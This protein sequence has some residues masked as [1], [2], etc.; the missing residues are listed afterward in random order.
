MAA[1]RSETQMTTSQL[2]KRMDR[3]EVDV[4]ELKTEV[5][6]TTSS[7]DGMRGDMTVLFTKMDQVISGTSHLAAMEGHIPTKYVTW[8][9]GLVVSSLFAF[10]SLGGMI[11]ALASGVVLFAM[12]SGDEKL[13]NNL[14]NVVLM[15]DRRHE[16]VTQ[17]LAGTHDDVVENRAMHEDVEARLRAREANAF[18][19]ADGDELESRIHQ[20]EVDYARTDELAKMTREQVANHIS[21]LD[22]PV[23]Q[24]FEGEGRDREIDLLQKKIEDLRRHHQ[25]EN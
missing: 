11:L 13:K 8:G 2:G 1:T 14:D 5:A 23:R 6:K 3:V 19:N 21:L 7:V 16:V 24:T 9:I 20:L 12:N 10:F 18:T 22:H 25:P 15:E 4:S 17:M